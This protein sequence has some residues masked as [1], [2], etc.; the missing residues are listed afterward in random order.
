MKKNNKI[1][2]N[3]GINDYFIV[4]WILVNKYINL[5]ITLE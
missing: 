1:N 5:I 2:R 3:I 4:V